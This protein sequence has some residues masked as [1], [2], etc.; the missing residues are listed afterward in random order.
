MELTQ[1]SFS[2]A[3]TNKILKSLAL[4]GALARLAA[5]LI[6]AAIFVGIM[7]W[8]FHGASRDMTLLTGLYSL[9]TF[10]IL[11]FLF[12]VWFDIKWRALSVRSML[13]FAFFILPLLPIFVIFICGL[14]E[15]L[16][17]AEEC[18]FIDA[19]SL[20]A[21]GLAIAFGG[22]LFLPP[23]TLV[24]IC[25]AEIS[26]YQLY[27][28]NNLPNSSPSLVKRLLFLLIFFPSRLPSPFQT[29]P[30]FRSKKYLEFL[31]NLAV[32]ATSTTTA[33]DQISAE[34]KKLILTKVKEVSKKAL[35]ILLIIM[36]LVAIAL[37]CYSL[38]TKIS[39]SQLAA[40]QETHLAKIKSINPLIKSTS[41][42]I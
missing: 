27:S 19:T 31:H 39:K 42:A 11:M 30:K 3:S 25:I 4:K 16:V 13:Y 2:A 41:P 28:S 37:G 26:H 5:A 17:H 20:Q 38:F 7:L 8:K 40:K 6:N 36:S 21:I 32:A 9:V 29:S 15:R 33:A 12:S 22:I 24:V 18:F 34:Q 14:N 23:Y 1:P 10:P 35:R